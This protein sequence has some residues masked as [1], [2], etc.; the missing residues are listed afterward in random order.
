MMKKPLAY[1][2]RYN[3]SR[4][5]LSFL[6]FI[7]RSG[8]PWVREMEPRR[9]RVA[10]TFFLYPKP[11]YWFPLLGLALQLYNVLVVFQDSTFLFLVWPNWFVSRASRSVLLFTTNTTVSREFWSPVWLCRERCYCWLAMPFTGRGEDGRN[12]VCT[13]YFGILALNPL[14]NYKAELQRGSSC[15][16]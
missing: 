16:G 12:T 1:M 14:F 15:E 11:Y 2:P 4:H 7:P 10:G 8:K 13:S 5:G 6:D 3:G 9:G